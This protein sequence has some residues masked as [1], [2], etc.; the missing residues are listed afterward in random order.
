VLAV[1]SHKLQ[2]LTKLKRLL[3]LSAFVTLTISAF[4]QTQ[5]NLKI[6]W[7]EEYKWKI[8]SNQEND[9]QQMLELIPG[10]ETIDKWS[11][12]GTML[13]IKGVKGVPMD[14]A[15]NLMFDQAKQNA[16]KPTLTMVERNDTA[17][18]A[19]IIFKIDAPRFKND[20]NPDSQLYYIIQGNLSLYS[21][22]VAIKEKSLSKDFLEKWIKIFKS[23][24]FI[25]Q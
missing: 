17:K 6:V 16:I 14:V 18:N 13:S 25:Y 1:I 3:I 23:S 4:G 5:E 15:M 9:K 22:F 11:I 2:Q 20:K 8:G 19:W 12:I 7:P 24:E 21:N 10:N